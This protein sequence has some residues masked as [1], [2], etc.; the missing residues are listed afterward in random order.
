MKKWTGQNKGNR[1][2]GYIRVSDVS[3]VDGHSLGAQRR[4]IEQWCTKNRYVLVK[5]YEDAGVSAHTDQVEKRPELSRLLQ[6]AKKAAFDIVVVHTLDRWARNVG[7]QRQTLQRLGEA[8]VGFASVMEGMDYTTP[9]GRLLL[10]T[11]GGVAEFFS[12]QLGLHVDKAQR[13]RVA[14]LGLAVGPVPFGYRSPE[15]R[16]APTIVPEEAEAILEVFHRRVEGQSH[17]DISRWLNGRSLRT[18]DGNA[19]T[20][21][22]IKDILNNRFYLG[23]VR[24]QGEVY[25]GKHEAIISQELF[26]RVQARKQRREFSRS[27]VGPKGLLQ[28]M[29]AC[30]H[31][32]NGLQSDR[33]RQQV[34][35]YRER[36][37]HQCP[38]NNTSIAADVVDRQVTTIVHSLGLRRDWRERM[39]KLACQDYEGPSVTELMEKRK[40][41]ARAYADG[42]FGDLEYQRR[43]SEIDGLITKAQSMKPAN[44]EE[45]VT[46]FNNIPLLW[47]E[48]TTEER[49]KL[50]SPLIR[51]VYVDLE[52][53]EVAI[54]IP[55]PPFEAMM[56]SAL[57]SAPG[58]PVLLVSSE[59]L[60]N[61]DV[62]GWWRRGRVELPVQR[63][64]S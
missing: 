33:H 57:E 31:C 1:A 3:Q 43:L 40:R 20:P 10:T 17:G 34:P 30:L 25:D 50:I 32:G 47:S 4:E 5:V 64:S 62:W 37:A 38:T 48:A 41:L 46:L 61:E 52:A 58:A 42:G 8:N 56:R 53:K 45:A 6:D 19:F 55:E 51:R 18:R 11:M 22:A 27:V 35:L 29:I 24:Y 49:R 63:T 13:Q 28:G 44:L 39:A 23:K 7:V 2:T 16:V 26:D 15:P 36:H 59:G 60:Q 14:V 9:S 54:L 12:D 21:H